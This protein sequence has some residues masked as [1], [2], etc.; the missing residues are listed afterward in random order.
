MS[1][2]CQRLRAVLAAAGLALAA[3]AAHAVQDCELN[4]QSVNPANGHTTAG[5][6]G[7]MRCQD[8]DTGHAPVRVGARELRRQH[9]HLLD[10]GRLRQQLR[11]LGHQGRGDPA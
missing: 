8:A 6:T 4:G 11:R 1:R 7:L 3:H 5:K 10:V 9:V 2:H